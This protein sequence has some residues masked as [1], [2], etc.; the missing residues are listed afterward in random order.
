MGT[1]KEMVDIVN[2][3]REIEDTKEKVKKTINSWENVLDELDRR[4]K[5]YEKIIRMYEEEEAQIKS[6]IARIDSMIK[7]N[8]QGIVFEVCKDVVGN[9]KSAYFNV[10]LSSFF[11]KQFRLQF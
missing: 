2:I 1:K 4:A 8:V 6:S 9:G 5:E 10:M 7:M 3:L 11:L